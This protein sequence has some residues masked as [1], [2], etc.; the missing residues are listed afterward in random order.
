MSISQR[1]KIATDVTRGSS[2]LMSQRIAVTL[3][4]IVYGAVLARLLGPV[5]LGLIALAN[6]AAFAIGIFS[7]VA[8]SGLKPAMIRNIA[9]YIANNENAKAKDI[10]KKGLTIHVLLGIVSTG[11]VLLT[12]DLVANFIFNTP[13]LSFL[14][15]LTAFSVSVSIATQFVSSLFESLKYFISYSTLMLIDTIGRMTF[16]L[17]LF[18]L[19]YGIPGIIAGGIISGSLTTTIGYLFIR[20]KLPFIHSKLEDTDFS[21]YKELFSFS[22][23]YSVGRIFYRIYE[24]APNLIL[25]Y[26]LT[27]EVVGYFSYANN[28]ANRPSMLGYAFYTTLLPSMSE[29]WAKEETSLMKKTYLS[30]M[31]YLMIFSTFF[32]MMLIVFANEI[33]LILAG[34]NFLPSVLL[35]Q[36]LALVSIFRIIDAP[37]LSVLLTT[38]KLDGIVYPSILRSGVTVGFLFLLVPQ[39]GAIITAI[40]VV[41]GRLMAIILNIVF[42]NRELSAHIPLSYFVKPIVCLLISSSILLLPTVTNLIIFGLIKLFSAPALFLIGMI[43]TSALVKE[44]VKIIEL[45]EI[46]NEL[47]A[48]IFRKIIKF[49]SKLLR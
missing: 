25:G 37:V 15:T 19:G 26:Y 45:I 1:S 32:S 41:I 24:L 36:I 8:V 3:M 49:I 23:F 13:E 5:N 31:K 22:L 17:L 28:I 29:T 6:S 34:P 11:L 9:V 18:F 4:A 44:D 43:L 20:R 48:Q 27:P 42:A 33:I 12:A 21:G 40:I 7:G 39:Y 10:Y 35:L 47:I 16:S 38:K 14:I 30:T 2:A 46:K